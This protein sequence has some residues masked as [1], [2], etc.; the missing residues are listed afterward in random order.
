MTTLIIA[1]HGNTFGEGEAPRRIGWRTDL[2][3]TETGRAQARALGVYLKDNGLLPDA[4]F[5]GRTRRTIETAEIAMIG[6]GQALYIQ[7]DGFFNE[8]G[9]GPDENRTEDDVRARVGAAALKEWDEK[10]VVPPGWEADP[11]EIIDGWRAFAGRIANDY[12]GCAVMAVTS[13][14]IARFAPHLTGDFEA[15]RVKH[16]L[17]LATGALAV[18]RHKGGVW[19]VEGWNVR[20]GGV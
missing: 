20:P 6:A 12:R 16:G 15:F 13:N 17:K 10:A 3:L 5:T 2:P 19:R 14:G 9:Y 11:A 7:P 4:V 18:M 1:R 8:I